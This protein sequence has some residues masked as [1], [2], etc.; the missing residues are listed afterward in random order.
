MTYRNSGFTLIELV[1]AL[2][3][4]GLLAAIAAP[5]F[6][7]FRSTASGVALEDAGAKV[8]SVSRMNMAK[9]QLSGDGHTT[10]GLSCDDF[11]AWAFNGESPDGVSAQA[12]TIGP[13]DT[14][15]VLEH[16]DYQGT[17][18]ALVHAVP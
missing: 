15:C 8:E 16:A 7:D 6:T 13:D 4:I 17:I 18:E 1:V 12:E 5:Q 14:L 10:V 11:V 2:V 9:H 3:I